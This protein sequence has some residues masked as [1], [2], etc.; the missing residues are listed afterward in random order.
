M[1][2]WCVN[3][4]VVPVR[5]WICPHWALS[6]KE[7]MHQPLSHTSSRLLMLSVPARTLMHPFSL[8]FELPV[9]ETPHLLVGI[10]APTSSRVVRWSLYVYHWIWTEILDDMEQAASLFLSTYPSPPN[11]QHT[12]IGKKRLPRRMLKLY[13]ISSYFGSNEIV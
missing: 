10:N 12:L 5:G 7:G 9:C 13:C 1:S 2:T 6:S 11:P 3:R 4:T 8:I